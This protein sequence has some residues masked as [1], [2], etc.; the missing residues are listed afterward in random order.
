MD[1][2]EISLTTFNAAPRKQIRSKNVRWIQGRD[3]TSSS[4]VQFV[5]F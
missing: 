3:I 4:C 5:H 1:L 2:N